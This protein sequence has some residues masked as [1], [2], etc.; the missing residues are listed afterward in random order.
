MAPQRGCFTKP[1]F[2]QKLIAFVS[3]GAASIT[4]G[5]FLGFLS[6]GTDV[7]VQQSEPIPLTIV[8]LILGGLYFG[9]IILIEPRLQS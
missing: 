8:A 4:V 1:T 5:S 7:A 9:Y 3:I 6:V 2:T